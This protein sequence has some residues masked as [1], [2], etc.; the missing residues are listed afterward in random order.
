MMRPTTRA[1]VAVASL[2]ALLAG[3]FAISASPA[4]AG[5]TP[6]LSVEKTVV[7][8]GGGEFDFE[9]GCETVLDIVAP[10]SVAEFSLMDGDI[11]VFTE[12]DLD[13]EFDDGV[14][15]WVEELVADGSIGVSIVVTNEDG[16]VVAADG[17][18]ED[19]LGELVEL[20]FQTEVEYFG[21]YF[22]DVYNFFPTNVDLCAVAADYIAISESV[23]L[24]TAT[25]AELEEALNA[26]IGLLLEAD[27]IGVPAEYQ[28]ALDTLIGAYFELNNILLTV[29]YDIELL[30]DEQ[31]AELDAIADA[32]EAAEATL[33]VGFAEACEAPAPPTPVPNPGT[34]PADAVRAR[35]AFTG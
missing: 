24:D 20:E 3:L 13:T 19:E 12:N 2:V 14:T 34:R 29:D 18:G 28:D 27:A 16:D 7:G 8:D 5:E 26:V 25:P 31:I 35:P 11:E 10:L 17:W 33:A 15:C 9:V 32:G 1:A 21:S 22:V 4:S 6:T 30:T 23:N